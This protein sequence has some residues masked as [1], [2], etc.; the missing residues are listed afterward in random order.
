MKQVR[1]GD[2]ELVVSRVGLGCN[3]FGPMIGKGM[4][5]AASRAVVDAA[6][7]A[8]I[9]FF[10]TAELYSDG[11]SERYL[12]EALGVRRGQVVIATKFGAGPGEP[13]KGSAEYVHAAIDRS[14]ERLGTDYVDLYFYHRPDGVTPIAETLG[15]LD[16]IVQAGKVRQIGCSNFTAEQL[17]EADETAR[18]LGTA[19]FVALQNEYSLLARDAEAELLPLCRELGVGFVPYFPLASGLLT[20]KYRRGESPPEGARLAD[21]GRASSLADERLDR[22][23]ALAVAAESLGRTLH[24]LAIAAVASTPGVSGVIA[25]ATRPEQVRANAA[26]AAWELGEDELAAIPRFTGAGPH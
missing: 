24:E 12:G 9:T 18:S 7:E 23:D 3:N 22:V 5:A 15:A 8:G 21:P 26:A 1:V 19:R 10:D 13:A 11:T 4:D 17:A 16:E 14:L 2:S 20:R 6:L 25:G